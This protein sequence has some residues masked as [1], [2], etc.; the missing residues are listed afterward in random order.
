MNRF[1]DHLFLFFLKEKIKQL[2]K[3]SQ[4]LL[5]RIVSPSF[6]DIQDE[7]SITKFHLAKEKHKTAVKL[8]EQLK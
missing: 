6:P 3:E 7:S 4:H 5:N 8:L 2:D 1:K